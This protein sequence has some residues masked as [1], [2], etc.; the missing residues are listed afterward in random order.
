MI[1]LAPAFPAFAGM[2]TPH[3][4]SEFPA[5]VVSLAVAVAG[6]F[7]LRRMRL[8]FLIKQQGNLSAHF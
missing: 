1:P 5:A 3:W 2:Q 6:V 7:L 8:K 4:F